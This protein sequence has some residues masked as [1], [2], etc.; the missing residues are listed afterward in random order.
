MFFYCREK[1]L[2]CTYSL[3]K[4]SLMTLEEMLEVPLFTF[5]SSLNVAETQSDPGLLRIPGSWPH[6][7]FLDGPCTLTSAGSHAQGTYIEVGVLAVRLLLAP[8]S[9][10]LW[11]SPHVPVPVVWFR[12]DRQGVNKGSVG[13]APPPPAWYPK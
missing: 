7:V 11:P 6:T 2:K 9:T 12:P 10:L 8:S 13:Q 4:Q 3:K 1:L 5:L